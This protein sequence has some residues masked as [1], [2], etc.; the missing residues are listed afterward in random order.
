MSKPLV[1]D[2]TQARGWLARLSPLQLIMHT[3]YAG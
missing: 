2:L 1:S 3:D